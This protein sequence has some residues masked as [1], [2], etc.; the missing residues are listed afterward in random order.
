[1]VWRRRWRSCGELVFTMKVMKGGLTQARRLQ[2][3]IAIGIAIAIEIGIEI[4]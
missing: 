4:E 3:G 2:I 1:M